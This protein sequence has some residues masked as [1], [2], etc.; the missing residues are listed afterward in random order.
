MILSPTLIA[1]TTFGYSR[2]R[3]LWDN[4]NQKG[5]ASRLGFPGL[6]G[7]SDATPRIRFSGP[8]GPDQLGRPGRQ[9]RQWQPDQHHLP[10]HAGLDLDARQA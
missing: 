5:W 1:H 9:G 6:S 8:D 4:P 3:Q 7:N 2:T 10:L